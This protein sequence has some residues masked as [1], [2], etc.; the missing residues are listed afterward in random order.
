MADAVDWDGAVNARR[1]AGGIYRMGRSEWVTETGW[2]QAWD[3][4]V[5][6]VI[7]LRNES[8]RARRPTDPQVPSRA[9][10]RFA[11]VHCPTEDPDN[12]QFQALCLPYLNHPRSYA[13]NLRLFPELVTGVFRAIA[14]AEGPVVVHCSAGRDR[15]GLISTMLLRLAGAG[16]AEIGTAYELSVRGIN[17]WHKVSP[18][19]HPHERYYPE[20]EL[21]P[22]LAERLEALARFA[23]GV[24]VADY[25]LDHGLSAAELA[26][27]RAKLALR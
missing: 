25:L 4:G 13:D 12:A 22:L 27:V 18:V 6:T 26:A 15:T 17:A 19:P 23:G 10:A 8:E 16:P 3:A 9:L 11:V 1:L 24:E 21:A 2:Q 5:R 7:D 20:A 14:A